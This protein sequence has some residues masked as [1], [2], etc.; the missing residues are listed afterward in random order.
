M[1]EVSTPLEAKRL[2]EL[3]DLTRLVWTRCG[4]AAEHVEFLQ[5]EEQPYLTA[6][7]KD[8]VTCSRYCIL[9]HLYDARGVERTAQHFLVTPADTGAE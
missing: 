5:T 8:R 4:A 3:Q 2:D 6:Y 7:R 1:G 9:S